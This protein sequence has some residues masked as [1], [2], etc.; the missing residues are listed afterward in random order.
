M[1]PDGGRMRHEVGVKEGHKS[2]AYQDRKR[3]MGLVRVSLA[4]VSLY[5]AYM[6]RLV[7]VAVAFSTP[8]QH[9]IHWWGFVFGFAK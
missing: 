4:L 9:V 8:I 7:A 5:F 3:E 6:D 1:G 2:Q